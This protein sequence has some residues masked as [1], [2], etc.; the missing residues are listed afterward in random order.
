MTVSS[1]TTTVTADSDRWN[2]DDGVYAQALRNLAADMARMAEADAYEVVCDY[3]DARDE[4][5]RV[6]TGSRVI[7]VYIPSIGRAM[8]HTNG[9]DFW[10]DAVSCDDALA[11]YSADT[12]VN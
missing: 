2:N 12:L 10:T 3:Q 11:C 8:L 4:D 9:G 6:I 1:H 7:A 5:D